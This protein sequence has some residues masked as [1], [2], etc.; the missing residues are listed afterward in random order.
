MCGADDERPSENSAEVGRKKRK[1]GD[2]GTH[3]GGST[4]GPG[5]RDGP[6]KAMSSAGKHSDREDGQ[7]EVEACEL[8]GGLETGGREEEESDMDG[9][10]LDNVEEVVCGFRTFEPPPQQPG[11]KGWAV[12]A[13]QHL[14]M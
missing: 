7:G 1:R 14:L 12:A 6:R 9:T 8:G 2:Q 11:N 3:H 4:S 13:L 5:E 10:E